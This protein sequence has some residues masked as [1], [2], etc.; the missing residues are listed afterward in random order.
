MRFA[1]VALGAVVLMAQS[2]T[3]LAYPPT[4]TVDVTTNY[5]GTT[6]A[7]PYRWLEDGKAPD[8]KTWAAAQTKLAVGYLHASPRYAAYARRVAALSRAST[9]RYRLTIRGG[10]W[11]YLR[12]TPPQPQPQLVVRDGQGAPER[13]LFDPR[14]AVQGGL[15]PSIEDIYVAPD[16]AK[17]AIGT[18]YGGSENETLEV[19]D[20]RS[21]RRFAGDAIPHAGGGTS[22]VALAW[23]ADGRGFLHTRFPR[24]PDGTY[25]T[26]GIRIYHHV[27][28]TDPADDTYVFGRGQS[29][30]SEYFL[31]T[32]PSGA[33]QALQVCDGDGVHAAIYLRR[34]GRPFRLVATPAA[35]I[36][37][38]GEA[39]AAFVGD[40]YDA[41][42]RERNGFGEVVA[43]VPG[44]AFATARV[45]VPPGRTVLEDVVPVAGGFATSEI[46]GGDARVRL[47][48]SDGTLRARLPIPPISSLTALT[49][50]PAG[51]PI[52]VGYQNYTTPSIWLR[53]VPSSGA[54]VPTGIADR[55]NGDFS[56]IV[57]ERVFVPSLDGKVK[58]PLEIVHARNVARDGT[59][60]TVMTAY[61]AYG[62]V[63][64]PYFDSTSLAWFERGGVFAL[65]M[66]RGG[67]EYGEA[68][69]LAARHATKTKSSD[70]LAACADWLAAHG[71]GNARHLGIIGASAGGFLM[72]LALTRDPSRYRAVVAQVGVLDL[73]RWILTPNGK[74]NTPEFGDPSNPAQ[75]RW[76]YAQSPYD[77]V[78]P[79]TAYPAVLMLTGENDPRVDPFDSRKMAARLQANSTSGLPILL[80]QRADQGHGIGS[81]FQQFVQTVTD[82]DTFFDRELR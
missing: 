12:L 23:D 14:D 71:Y 80:I 44:G 58:I 60:P 33:V 37:D 39:Q 77:N 6:V 34:R 48:A 13:V 31:A 36:G 52:V 74:Y 79:D 30:R 63:S 7:D 10:R 38:S 59:A 21:G 26:A 9:L 51:G 75:F 54:L 62:I 20:A 40:D 43:L 81:S 45:V 19:I 50:D 32:S 22:P 41:I 1:A 15:Q 2:A 47:F 57:A 35:G 3:P 67:G 55:A 11:F 53:Y 82:V 70:D 8:V 72:G 73:L 4:K 69:H 5:F 18:Q 65:A 17:V 24:N 64:Q 66:I 46:D 76:M 78:H 42:A 28:G 56:H 61:G 49:G 25:P 68:W 16:G 27:L 29:P